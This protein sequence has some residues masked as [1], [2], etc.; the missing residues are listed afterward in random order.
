MAVAWATSGSDG[1]Q[2]AAVGG[3][4][5]LVA[6]GGAGK[7]LPALQAIVCEEKSCPLPEIAAFIRSLWQF[8]GT[9]KTTRMHSMPDRTLWDLHNVCS[10]IKVWNGC[11]SFSI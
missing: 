5:W 6:E 1:W 3:K 9:L 10:E 11:Q 8:V 2:H 7:R 4:R